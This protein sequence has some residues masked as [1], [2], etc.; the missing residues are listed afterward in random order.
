MDQPHFLP[1]ISVGLFNR[2]KE[3]ARMGQSCIVIQLC[4]ASMEAFVNEYIEIGTKLI[5]AKEKHDKRQEENQKSILTRGSVSYF[6]GLPKVEKDL[7]NTLRTQESERKQIF[8]KIN[9]II[10]VCTG[11]QWNK[12][13]KVYQ[14]Y[15]TLIN[16]RNAL[17]HPR[18]QLVTLGSYN[19]PDC[20]KP[21]YRQKSKDYFKHVNQYQSW[22]DAIDTSVFANWCLNA[23]INIM[24]TM[25][26]AMSALPKNLEITRSVGVTY[27]ND[28]NFQ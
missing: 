27:L 22:I 17:T 16:L 21:F 3:A 8:I 20:L 12:G 24:R 23:F 19:Y 11:K 28:F 25:L 15:C 18:S 2:A 1:S 6:V 14:D 7:I 13:D 9:T 4:S 10:E 5:Q 26:N